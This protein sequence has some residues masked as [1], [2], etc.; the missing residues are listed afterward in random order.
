MIEDINELDEE[1]KKEV[2]EARAEIE[3]GKF[4]IRP[5]KSKKSLDYEL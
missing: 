2:E 1:T 5:T 4:R 3:T